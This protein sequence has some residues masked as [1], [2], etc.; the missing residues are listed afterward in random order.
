MPRMAEVKGNISKK[1]D[2]RGGILH[3]ETYI[4]REFWLFKILFIRKNQRKK[5]GTF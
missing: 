5:R 2:Y 4:N 1:E 3:S